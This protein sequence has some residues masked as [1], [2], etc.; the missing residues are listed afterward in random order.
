[1]R[2]GIPWGGSMGV[3]WTDGH[4]LEGYLDGVVGPEVVLV[5]RLEPAC[6]VL[7]QGGRSV[8]SICML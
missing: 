3:G 8:S 2:D 1:M 7:G 5:D 6:V 4:S